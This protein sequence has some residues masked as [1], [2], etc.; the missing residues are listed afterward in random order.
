LSVCRSRSATSGDC[1]CA[2]LC[3][4][5]ARVVVKSTSK[6]L[7]NSWGLRR[8][9]PC[10]FRAATCTS[11][12]QRQYPAIR[13]T[14]MMHSTEYGEATCVSDSSLRFVR[15]PY[16]SRARAPPTTKRARM[17]QGFKL[18]FVSFKFLSV[19]YRNTWHDVASTNVFGN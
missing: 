4:A 1:V 14:V 10:I 16:P 17:R 3:C 18:R 15:I 7:E 6:D 19:P 8:R 2:F 9:R 13:F 11:R 12:Q 5:Y